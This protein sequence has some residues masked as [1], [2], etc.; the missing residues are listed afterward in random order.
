M[1]RRSAQEWAP[2]KKYEYDGIV[3][4]ASRGPV[5]MYGF[6][7]A[8]GRMKVRAL[9]VGEP[10]DGSVVNMGVKNDDGTVCWAD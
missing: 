4:A 6:L 7:V 10:Y 9:F 5:R 3:A 1:K 8:C 2:K